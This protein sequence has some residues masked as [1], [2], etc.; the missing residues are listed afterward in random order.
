M[1]ATARARITLEGYFAR[2]DTPM[3]NSPTGKLMAK[4]LEHSPEMDLDQCRDI[5]HE[6]LL[7]VGGKHR[8]ADAYARFLKRSGG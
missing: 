6:C 1:A 2:A 7:G 5:A 3:K 4:I 8:I